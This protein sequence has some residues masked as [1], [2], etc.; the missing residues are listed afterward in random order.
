MYIKT[1]GIVL[2]EIEYKDNDKLL[3]V[4]TQELGKR[5]FRA[6]GVKSSRSRMRS[7]CQLL[8]YS[9]MTLFEYRDH[10]TLNEA[11]PLE[12]FWGVRSDVEKLAL[13]SYFAEVLEN[14]AGEGV[15]DPALLSLILNS[16]YALDKL[17]K[18][19]GLVKSAFELKLMALS[20]YEPLLDACAVCG[21]PEP[22]DP[23][24]QLTDGVLHCGRCRPE[25][26]EGA[27][28]PLSK[29]VLSA[30]RHVIYGDPK[31][32]FSFA[33]GREELERMGRICERFL[34]TQLD[35]GFRTLDFYKTL[36]VPAC[37]PEGG[38]ERRGQTI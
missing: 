7:A 20:G 8:A 29:G 12:L 30:M 18:P 27:S 19:L 5:T 34:V 21:T 10:Y 25:A 28:V 4:L 32:L 17:N 11:E 33:L 16:L 31:R 1:S 15:A 37:P 9:E 3:T 36:A 22:E 6:R 13:G 35:R 24:F 2:R 23:R 26:G 14:L 38:A